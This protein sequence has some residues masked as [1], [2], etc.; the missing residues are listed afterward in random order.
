MNKINTRELISEMRQML[1]PN[2]MTCEGLVYGED[3]DEMMYDKP[4]IGDEEMGG[5]QA[6]Q[7]LSDM[8]GANPG[9]ENPL[10]GDP[11]ITKL[12][13]SI[14]VLTLKG[15]TKLA[16]N[17]ETAQYDLLKKIFLQIDKSVE[18][19]MNPEK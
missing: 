4:A 10:D 5:D 2:K 16:N 12:I 18:D 14:R 3:G 8:A 19:K 7:Q 17:P 11:E 15:L 9:E 13:T 6:M 1:G